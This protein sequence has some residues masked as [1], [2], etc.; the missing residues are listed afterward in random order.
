MGWDS[1]VEI[2]ILLEFLF[3]ESR[4]R[5]GFFFLGRN[6]HFSTTCAFFFSA[7]RLQAGITQHLSFLFSTK[8]RFGF[9][10]Y[11]FFRVFFGLGTLGYW[12][13][14]TLS[15]VYPEPSAREKKGKG[16]AF[17][18]L[19]SSLSTA[20]LPRVTSSHSYEECPA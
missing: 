17:R 7:Y 8:S 11:C 18:D 20:P 1:V 19:L 13:I 2:L 12:D 9:W 3:G 14:S 4:Q 15:R 10:G 6:Y 16:K 5:R